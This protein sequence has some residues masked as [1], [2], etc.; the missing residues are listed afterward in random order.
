MKQVGIV[1]WYRDGGTSYY[2][3]AAK[4]TNGTA[5][6]SNTTG[7]AQWK[8]VQDT[9][10]WDMLFT[11]G[12]PAWHY[13]ISDRQYYAKSRAT[14][15]ASSASGAIVGNTA[16]APAAFGS[17]YVGFVVDTTT[18]KSLVT[19]PPQTGFIQNLSVVAG[20]SNS[21]LSMNN[22][23]YL[24]IWYT[25]G[26]DEFYWA[27]GG[28]GAANV[29]TQL[30][31]KVSGSTGTVTWSYPCRLPPNQADCL[32]VPHV[33]PSIGQPDGTIYRIA[34][35][36]KD[37]AG[38]LETPTTAQMTLDQGGPSVSIS[39]P[40]AVPYNSYG[41][42]RDLVQLR[43]V[44]A[45]APANV[46]Y[47][48][49][50]VRNVSDSPN[51]VWTGSAWTTAVSSHYFVATATNPWTYAIDGT[52]WTANK[53]YRIRVQAYD[54][55]G[56]PSATDP[57]TYPQRFFVYDVNKPSSTFTVPA[58]DGS[59]FPRGQPAALSG[60]AFDWRNNPGVEAKSGLQKVEIAVFKQGAPPNYWDGLTWDT[61]GSE[62]WRSASTTTAADPAT[63]TLPETWTYPPSS[64][65]GDAAAIPWVDGSSYT[66]KV[67]S[68]DRTNNME[69]F[70]SRNFV[71]DAQAPTTTVSVPMSSEYLAS[72]VLSSGPYTEATTLNGGATVQI[73]IRDFLG[74]YWDGSAF[75]GFGGN[76]WRGG[77]IESFLAGSS[78]TFTDAGLG[79]AM[80]AGGITEPR[81]YTLFIRGVDAAGNQN[82]TN[83]NPFGVGGGRNFTIDQF[84]PVSRAT[85]PAEGS[86]VAHYVTPIQGTASD[87]HA[88]SP[89][90]VGINSVYF[91]GMREDSGG[92]SSR[93]FWNGT[94]WGS[95]SDL[96]FNLL[97]NIIGGAQSEVTIQSLGNLPESAFQDGYRYRIASQ[98]TDL[99]GNL[100]IANSTLTFVFDRSTPTAA[101]LIPA[102]AALDI[103]SFN[104][105]FSS[106]THA[107]S[108]PFGQAVVS[109]VSRVDFQIR[110]ISAGPH[111]IPSTCGGNPCEWWN[112][113]AWTDSADLNAISSRAA[114]HQSSWT[115]SALPADWVRGDAAPDGRQY[116][117]RIRARDNAGNQGT[118]PAQFTAGSLATFDGTP[119]LSGVVLPAGPDNGVINTLASITGTATDPVSNASSS[120][121]KAVYLAIKS[122]PGNTDGT[123]NKHWDETAGDWAPVAAGVKW[124]TTNWNGTQ[125]TFASQALDP[126][127]TSFMKYILVSSATDK[128]GNSQFAAA[129][130]TPPYRIKEFQPPPAVSTVTFPLDG[131]YYNRMVTLQGTANDKTTRVEIKLQR[132]DTNECWGGG[133]LFSGSPWV[134]CTGATVSTATR[135]VY[136][137]G[138]NW[139]YP[140]GNEALPNW[141]TVND[142]TF[143]LTETGYN[144]FNI[145]ELQPTGLSFVIDMSS[146]V[147]KVI[148]PFNNMA[149]A[150]PPTIQGTTQDPVYKEIT[151]A[152]KLLVPN[153]VRLRLKMTAPVQYWEEHLAAW[154]PSPAFS[155][156]AIGGLIS[157]T[158]SPWTWATA[159]PGTVWTAG[160]TYELGAS[161]LDKAVG[162]PAGANAEDILAPITFTYDPSTPTV[163]LQNPNVGRERLM[164][165]ISG[166]SQDEPLGV[167]Q[168]SAVQV[169][170]QRK[171]G[172]EFYAN[173]LNNMVFDGADANLAWATAT[174]TV[175][176]DNWTLS[177][178]IP[179]VSGSTYTVNARA[180]DWAASHSMVYSTYTFV[181]D[182]VPPSSTVLYPIHGSTISA[183]ASLSGTMTDVTNASL[184]DNINLG[185]V[186]TMRMKL[187]RLSDGWYWD[188]GSWQSGEQ[189]VQT[190]LAGMEVWTTSWTIN[191]SKLPQTGNGTLTSGTSYYVTSSG[192]DD[193]ADGGNP[194]VWD[195][196]RGSTFTFDN[197]VP[198]TTI[199][200]PLP[201]RK[202]KSLPTISGG[203]FDNVAVATV[204]ISIEQTGKAPPN[205]YRTNPDNDFE[206]ACPA[207][208]KA[209]GAP[210]SWS[211]TFSPSTWQ[212][213][214]SYVVYS[215]ATDMGGVVQ[216]ALSSAAFT[217]DIHAPTA[218]LTNPAAWFNNT[219]T[220]FSGATNDSPAGVDLVGPNEPRVALSSESGG[221]AG[222]WW[223]GV[224]FTG[225]AENYLATTGN[226]S[227]ALPPIGNFTNG[228]T[229][230]VRV[231]TRDL[232]LPTNERVQSFTRS[233]DS[234]DP[235]GSLANPANGSYKSGNF[236]ISGNATDPDPG[237]P[238]VYSAVSTV[239]ISIME[240]DGTPT[241]YDLV[242]NN[243]AAP[244]CPSFFAVT[245]AAPFA[246]WSFTPVSAPYANSKRYVVLVKTGDNAGNT[247]DSYAAGVSSNTFTY[248][249]T[250]STIGITNP[251]LARERFPTPITGMAGDTAPGY[252]GLVQVR[253][254]RMNAPS[255]YA[256]PG[257]ALAWNLDVGDPAQEEAAFFNATY[258]GINWDNWT[259]SS[260]NFTSGDQYSFEARSR[261]N[262][263][264]WSTSYA[265]APF[266]YDVDAP[267]TNVQQPANNSIVAVSTKIWGGSIDNTP[268]NNGL[269]DRLRMSLKRLSDDRFW[270]GGGWAPGQQIISQADG[271]VI[272]VSSWTL[273]AQPPL[274][275]L[276]DLDHGTSYY[277]TTSGMDNSHTPGAGNAEPWFDAARASTFTVDK[278]APVTRVTTPADKGVFPSVPTIG[279]TVSD[280]VA[281]VPDGRT[282][283]IEVSIRERTPIGA[284]WNGN[285]SAPNVG[286]FTVATENWVRLDQIA[287]VGANPTVAAGFWSFSLPNPTLLQD[288][289]TYQVRVRARDAA[290]PA[291]NGNLE[292][293]VSSI[294][295]TPDALQAGVLV[296]FPVALPSAFGKLKSLGQLRGTAAD[297]FGII[298]AS[299]SLR[300][301]KEPL[302]YYDTGSGAFTSASEKWLAVDSLTGPAPLFNWNKSIAGIELPGQ[303]QLLHPGQ[304]AGLLRQSGSLLLSRLSNP[305]RHHAPGGLPHFS[306]RRQL[307]A[308]DDDRDRR[309][310]R[311]QPLRRGAFRKPDPHPAGVGRLLLGRGLGLG[312]GNLADS[313]RGLSLDQ[314]RPVP[315]RDHGRGDRTRGHQ[316]VQDR[317][318]GL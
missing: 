172:V 37:N 276:A 222:S 90:G 17:N 306:G 95:A 118:F 27:G 263:G 70:V 190:A 218:T 231:R 6:S 302:L 211:F 177:S 72:F 159:F 245:G 88:V 239:T 249:L 217:F 124:S 272:H 142:T 127:L 30:P 116:M 285:V 136:P 288:Q 304:G 162:M 273:T 296:T 9:D 298:Y 205:C 155:T 14:D 3:R 48:N 75:S 264:N 200:A 92:L 291:W 270:T 10:T 265:T 158:T 195:S 125:W 171:S 310:L 147:S 255:K 32:P 207:W 105:T 240:D 79:A 179:W 227:L 78:W 108:Y 65:A 52:T 216:T 11:D 185:S 57:E 314:E 251:D 318:P 214:T 123:A 293:D 311:P 23:Y 26:A 297:D 170:V 63:T 146:P 83:G 77:K 315:A 152:S 2:Y 233:Y 167:G 145:A 114:A 31:V 144:A 131:G 69:S 269:V 128:A 97:A 246:A 47:V 203:S 18:P 93:R 148:F 22:T 122:D 42:G 182:V 232:A 230:M 117:L 61:S 84:R 55:A 151:A 54:T 73:A 12:S 111:T 44:S 174:Y 187:R 50:E 107:E 15:R 94:N 4:G 130:G 150:V 279:G 164:S 316:A 281:G 262:A 260:G 58:A 193:A 82:R 275:T 68:Y 74:S 192:I 160:K 106:G 24:R 41:P 119:P 188:G 133:Q 67:R 221:A 25:S 43:G 278:I 206:G 100:E 204:S 36:A 132:R 80:L 56:N 191:P 277:L 40:M 196:P 115:F 112:G 113:E 126:K 244:A 209:S 8:V 212:H 153:G 64:P 87:Q 312:R 309:F 317:F 98:G 284:Y 267:I 202:Y 135:V 156:A 134:S 138:A 294:T 62:F 261:D 20:T 242:A 252:V 176:W 81:T 289:R 71:Y 86:Y 99:L 308:F 28:W 183:L 34:I 169:R 268:V 256:N 305:H 140:P 21:D 287:G 300:S 89:T 213:N 16:A 163:V 101:F 149:V 7:G 258:S 181:Y 29:Q 236:T 91:K 110:D 248:D 139:S 178:G 259:V 189:V 247:D 229:Y 254:R 243:F 194:E 85:V 157:G 226:W 292:T 307:L 45:D 154:N 282:D 238:L 266:V 121:V 137:A 143:T 237:A 241:C 1:V 120:S 313:R 215:T 60:Q 129:P 257:A 76:S 102:A 33:S 103:S 250:A 253:L 38:N 173:P 53:Q 39:T 280:V 186:P 208:F 59:L 5:F 19:Q 168:V 175:N 274:P 180:R 295:F 301:A 35:Q 219:F 46:D 96:G 66:V 228:K 220:D 13:W 49:V 235:V 198:N 201:G 234:V 223:N 290:L 51:P 225:L 104:F 184:P 161:G 165:V 166:T 283:L 286:T 197:S 303:H 109:S 199:A 299:V 210:A 271:I 224:D 141:T